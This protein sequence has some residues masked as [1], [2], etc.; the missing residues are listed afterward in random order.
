MDSLQKSTALAVAVMYT[1]GVIV[2]ATHLSRF[3]VFDLELAKVA[4]LL[5]GGVC[6]FY[7]LVR[8]GLAVF[9]IDFKVILTA[10]AGAEHAI[11]QNLSDTRPFKLL[12]AASSWPILKTLIGHFG[13]QRIADQI[14]KLIL[15]VTLGLIVYVYLT[16][17]E[18]SKI[19]ISWQE[20]AEIRPFVAGL[21][22]IQLAY[23]IWLYFFRSFKAT[24][25]L[26]WF[27][28]FAFAFFLIADIGFYSLVLHPLVKSSFGGG[29]VRPVAV[30]VGEQNQSLR[31]FLGITAV[32]DS[33]QF[34][35]LHTAGSAYYLTDTFELDYGAQVL[36]KIVVPASV[37]RVD[38]SE[39]PAVKFLSN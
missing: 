20:A 22:F 3:G 2:T 6:L 1:L 30:F 25:L 33:G 5:A 19:D 38:K 13:P 34:Y 28:N 29:N 27:W 10:I 37:T 7:L 11:H 4:Y 9:I 35:L 14:I 23:I 17:F 16:L 32:P 24:K 36:E 26:R 8:L 39:I 12:A 31:N 18:L 15:L 21:L